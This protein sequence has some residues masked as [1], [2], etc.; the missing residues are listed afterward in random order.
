MLNTDPPLLSATTLAAVTAAM[1]LQYVSKH[2]RHRKQQQRGGHTSSLAVSHTLM[3][4]DATTTD[5]NK[6]VKPIRDRV[7]EYRRAVARAERGEPAE[8][9]SR[10][11]IGMTEADLV[12]T[13][14]EVSEMM[15]KWYISEKERRRRL[16][17]NMQS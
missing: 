15:K 11:L 12:E 4:L 17:R 5:I 2:R 14:M 8:W 16:A 10:P 3:G 6:L 13:E 1:E 9:G 7:L